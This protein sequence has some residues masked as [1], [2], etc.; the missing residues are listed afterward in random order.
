MANQEI[1]VQSSQGSAAQPATGPAPSSKEL[2]ATM[3][4]KSKG[5]A[6]KQLSLTPTA[7]ETDPSAFWETWREARGREAQWR[8]D[9]ELE[10]REL[11]SKEDARSK[12][13]ETRARAILAGNANDTVM[14]L[15]SNEGVHDPKA[16]HDDSEDAGL[17]RLQR[18]RL[19]R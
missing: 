13:T 8:A 17:K 15:I 19:E 14:E 3:A 6:G 7:A 1:E 11:M 9:D 4:K 18:L 5:F 12:E 10:E 16:D 2:A